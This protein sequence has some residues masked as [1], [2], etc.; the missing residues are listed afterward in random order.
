MLLLTNVFY[1]GFI[2]FVFPAIWLLT[3]PAQ[4]LPPPPISPYF[5]VLEYLLGPAA[6]VWLLGCD[7]LTSLRA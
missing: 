2:P 1:A 3:R 7:V 6:G 5:P 4:P